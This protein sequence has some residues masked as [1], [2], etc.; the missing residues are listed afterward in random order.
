MP[1]EL[2]GMDGMGGGRYHASAMALEDSE[3]YGI[4]YA[5]I[6]ELGRENPSLQR[7]VHQVLA[8]EIVRSQGV[9]MLLGSMSAEARLAAFLLNLSRRLM[10]RGYSR[11]TFVLRMTREEIGSYLGLKLETVSRIFSSLQKRG[12][13]EVQQKRI[14]I[15]DPQGLE[16]RL[17]Q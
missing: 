5:L 10:R 9:M 1:G 13:L 14:V 17:A 3:V 4:P 7:R 11:S 16:S 12:L 15:V 8:A 6:E 2:L